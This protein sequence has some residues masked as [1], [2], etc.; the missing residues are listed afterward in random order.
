M[1]KTDVAKMFSEADAA[2]LTKVRNKGLHSIE[3][4][5]H[6]RKVMQRYWALLK[7]RSREEGYKPFGDSSYHEWLEQHGLP[8][9]P[10]C[11]RWYRQWKN[12]EERPRQKHCREATRLQRGN[13]PGKSHKRKV[14]E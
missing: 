10:Y 9:R 8:H 3:L 12:G 14:Q 7:A 2:T 6:E 1:G 5:P 11:D 4:S 13:Y